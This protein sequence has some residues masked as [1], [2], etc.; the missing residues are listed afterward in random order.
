MDLNGKRILITGASSG[1]G[2]EIMQKLTDG[3]N[4]KIAAV[5]RSFEDK[6][7]I[8][9]SDKVSFFSYDLS[10][11]ENIDKAVDDAINALGG[12]DCIIACA[13]FGYFEKFEDKDYNHIQYIYDVN[14]VAPLYML[15]LLLEKTEGKIS[16]TVIAS[17]LGKM[18]LA[19]YSLYCSSKFALDGFAHAYKY[20]VP[21][22]LHFMTVYPVGVD[23]TKFYIRN[24]DDMP[25]PRPLQS[26]D[27][28]AEAVIKGIEK[29]K[30]YVYT[31][32][33]FMFGYALNRALPFLFPVY[34]KLYKRKFYAWLNKKDESKKQH[35]I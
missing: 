22:R 33:A 31:S 34:Q 20:E 1:I 2:K 32:R 13:G 19:G 6:S 21:D 12:I 25:L 30:R 23:D 10:V 26:I 11:K 28:V 5:A 35:D 9:G 24:S 27:R 8:Q 17:A 3:K 15:Q 18:G 7:D 29:S 14:V 16:F 4:C